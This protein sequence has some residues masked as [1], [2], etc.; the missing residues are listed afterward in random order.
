LPTTVAARCATLRVPEDRRHPAGRV[1][2]VRIARVAASAKRARPDPVVM[3]A[4]GPGQSALDAFPQVAAAFH[5][6]LRERDVILVD[7]RGTGQS[8]PLECPEADAIEV[9]DFVE[10]KLA[11]ELTEHCLG[12]LSAKSDP[13]FYTTSDYVDDLE[14]V[15]IALGIERV[16]L[17]GISYGTRVALE[18]VRRHAAHTR[19]VVLDAVVPP[20][21]ILGADHAS[22]LEAVIN[23]QFARCEADAVCREKFGSPRAR[24]DALLA[25]LREH[26]ERV[27][28]LDP[29]TGESREDTLTAA[30]VAGVVRMYAYAPQLFGMLPM[31]LAAAASGDYSTLMANAHMIEELV[32]EQ[33]S[34]ALQLS[35]SCAEDVPWLHADP[36]DK[37]TLLG[38]TFVD[39]LQAQ[40]AVWPRGRVPTDFHEPVSTSLPVLLLS[41]E[42]DPVTPPRY[43]ETVQRTL[44]NSR[45]FTVKG[46]GHSVLTAGCVPQLLTKFVVTAQTGTLDGRCLDRLI[47]SPPFGGTYGWEP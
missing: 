36:R 25:K 7:Q 29:L 27:A 38:T 13:R 28:Y 33:I 47:E 41:G 15:R 42:L 39:L 26:P 46:G 23:L 32:G 18:Y 10:P 16:N 31:T 8:H 43:G 1:I 3:L 44:P 21:L 2:E 14:A 45:H 20:Q 12:E 40:C 37:D 9:D 6:V 11:R 19:A 35:V 34:M 17:V 5:G 22:N 4:G 24:L 30:D